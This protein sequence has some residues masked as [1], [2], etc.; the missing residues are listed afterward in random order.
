MTRLEVLNPDLGSDI[1][2]NLWKLARGSTWSHFKKE[3][4]VLN[5]KRTGSEKWRDSAS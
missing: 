4:E 2:I 3:L 1:P 5:M